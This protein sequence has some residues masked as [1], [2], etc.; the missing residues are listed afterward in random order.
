[1]PL[2]PKTAAML[3]TVVVLPSPGLGDVTITTGVRRIATVPSA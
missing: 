3:A 1:M 2:S